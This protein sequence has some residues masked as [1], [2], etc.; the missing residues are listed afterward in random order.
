MDAPTK[1]ETLATHIAQFWLLKRM[2]IA[3]TSNKRQEERSKFLCLF[4]DSLKNY[5]YGH[6]EAKN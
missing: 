5:N 1:T 6:E 3:A 2:R 4:S